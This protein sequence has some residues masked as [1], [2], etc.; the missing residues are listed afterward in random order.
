MVFYHQNAPELNPML[1]INKK[2]VRNMKKSFSNENQN[3]FAQTADG[4]ETYDRMSSM[5]ATILS[6]LGELSSMTPQNLR[7]SGNGILRELYVDAKTLDRYMMTLPSLSSLTPLQYEDIKES[8]LAIQS[9][10][11]QVATLLQGGAGIY[12]TYME[13]FNRIFLRL[14]GYLMN[15]QIDVLLHPP[16]PQADDIMPMDIGNDFDDNDDDDI[17]PPQPPNDEPRYNFRPRQPPSNPPPSYPRHERDEGD[18]PVRR[19]RRGMDAHIIANRVANGGVPIDDV[20][21]ALNQG[22]RIRFPPAEPEPRS[23]HPFPLL[24]SR[25]V[26]EGDELPQTRSN[27]KSK[28]NIIAPPF[29]PYLV[30]P[31]TRDRYKKAYAP[32]QEEAPPT[33][34]RKLNPA[35]TVGTKSPS[36]PKAVKKPRV[37]RAAE[38]QTP[39]ANPIL[40]VPAVPLAERKPKRARAI[41]VRKVETEAGKKTKKG[42]KE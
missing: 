8:I 36:K 35:F 41:T 19:V 20:L 17:P 18:I 15:G 3:S 32:P 6:L 24:P 30:V 2:I 38:P 4:K 14:Q 5:L 12:Q 11:S 26:R 21:G 37:R 42:R 33:R 31:N 23:A 9:Y 27:K 1:P 34:R 40:F 7:E 28:P 16:A 10:N 22:H 13:T 39:P 29:N 25:R